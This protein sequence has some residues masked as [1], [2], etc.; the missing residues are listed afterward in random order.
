[1]RLGREVGT[2]YPLG[3]LYSLSSL[4]TGGAGGEEMQGGEGWELVVKGKVSIFTTR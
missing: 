4:G 1:M 3:F 2:D